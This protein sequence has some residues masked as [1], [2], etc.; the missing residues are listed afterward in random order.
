MNRPKKYLTKST[1]EKITSKALRI[2]GSIGAIARVV[3]VFWTALFLRFS[4][5]SISA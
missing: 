2:L 1:R 3:Y 4:S 5:A